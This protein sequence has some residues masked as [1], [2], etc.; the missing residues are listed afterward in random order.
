[1][2]AQ[3][4]Y[5]FRVC[6]FI[7]RTYVRACRIPPHRRTP[8]GADDHIGPF[9]R[10]PYL[11]VGEGFYPSRRAP[12]CSP[13]GFVKT[14]VCPA[15]AE[16]V[17]GPYRILRA[18]IGAYGFVTSYRAGGVE[19]LPYGKFGGFIRI[20]IGAFRFAKSFCMGGASLSPT[21][22][23]NEE[24]TGAGLLPCACFPFLYFAISPPAVSISFLTSCTDFT[25]SSSVAM[26]SGCSPLTPSRKY[27]S[28]L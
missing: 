2:P 18:C 20:H 15:R 23:R 9:H 21:L 24:K 13:M 16:R 6:I 4:C 8:V 3:I 19:P 5:F 10:P 26:A 12:S 25:A 22:R 17:I 7:L 14:A 27:L 11:D 1:M 28:S